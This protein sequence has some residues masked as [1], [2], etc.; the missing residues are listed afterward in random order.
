VAVA[1]VA[2]HSFLTGPLREGATVLDLGANQGAFSKGLRMRWP[3]RCVA[4]EPVGMHAAQIP[5]P[6][7]VHRLA[8]GEADRETQIN[9]SAGRE[10]S[11]L[12]GR[13][14]TVRSERVSEVRFATLLLRLGLD[15]VA[16]VK[17]DIE[18]AERALFNSP[19]EV[20]RR[21]AQFTVEFHDH[22]ALMDAREVREIANRL[23]AIGFVRVRF[24]RTNYNWLFFQPERCGIG[25]PWFL[26]HVIRNAMY[27]SRNTR[28]LLHVLPR[29][30]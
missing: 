27:V 1:T 23:A 2:E 24:T 5:P 25:H 26:R 17:V 15:E 20:L 21:C 4:V 30:G 8:L 7:E 6:V 19:A 14:D 18:G 9:V 12:Y 28:R 11:S 3:V 29:G 16:L 22:N 10:M 13:T